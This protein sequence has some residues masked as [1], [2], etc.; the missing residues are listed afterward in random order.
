VVVEAAE[1]LQPLEVV[2]VVDG[3]G[4]ILGNFKK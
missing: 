4:Y 2:E 3:F 1:E